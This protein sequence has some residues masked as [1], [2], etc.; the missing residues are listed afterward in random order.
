MSNVL[1][2]AT[3]KY[4]LPEYPRYLAYMC[5]PSRSF[6]PS[7][8]LAF[9]SNRRIHH[10]IPKMLDLIESVTLSRAGVESRTDLALKMRERLLSLVAILERDQSDRVGSDQQVIFLSEPHSIQTIRLPHDIEQDQPG[11]F[12]QGHR[13]VSAANLRKFPRT[14]SELLAL[15]GQPE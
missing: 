2:V 8:H 5:P 3:G 12:T 1:V 13:Y 9:Y 7:S 4:E 14:I 6:Q 11:A 15:E 10:V